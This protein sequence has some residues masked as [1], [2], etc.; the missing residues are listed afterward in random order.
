[1]EKINSSPPLNI[2]IPA[3]NEELLIEQTVL[4][5]EKIKQKVRF[6]YRLI[7]VNDNSTDHTKE[8][9]LK[10][11]DKYMDLIV[12]NRK[13]NHGLGRCIN[14]A[15]EEVEKG[16][17]VTVMADMADN[18]EDI[19]KMYNK[20]REGYDLVCASRYIK[21]GCG[22]HNNKLKGFLSWLL[23]KSLHLLTAIP[24]QDA[25]NAYKMFK[26][27]LIDK[28]GIIRSDNYTFGLEITL[29]AFKAGCRIAEIPTAWKDRTLGISHFK[30]LKIASEYLYWFFWGLIKTA[31]K[32]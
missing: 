16:V 2:I 18:V 26:V 25:A 30:I 14:R 23:G 11:K 8:I 17:V 12:I 19:L 27:E 15:L 13:G 20:I 9:L 7:V 29:K 3:Y 24:T 22:T 28:I 5:I 1:M 6:L 31:N 32:K 21:G 10:L 4:T